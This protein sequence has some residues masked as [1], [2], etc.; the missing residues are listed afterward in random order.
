MYIG[1]NILVQSLGLKGELA[2]QEA[3]ISVVEVWWC[4]T[5]IGN[6]LSVLLFM[7][8]LC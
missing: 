5:F 8:E 1:L 7:E 4:V 3:E 2:V 6:E